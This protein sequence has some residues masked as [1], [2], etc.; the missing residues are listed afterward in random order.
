VHLSEEGVLETDSSEQGGEPDM[1]E[2]AVNLAASPPGD[3]GGHDQPH[4]GLH[5]C[6]EREGVQLTLTKLLEAASIVKE[7]LP[8]L[9]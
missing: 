5:S 8:S 4:R 7:A 1:G 6:G 2:R 9:N 3:P